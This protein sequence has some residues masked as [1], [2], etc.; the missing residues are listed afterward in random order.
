MPGSKPNAIVRCQA[1][2]S[3]NSASSLLRADP[4]L[5]ALY[6]ASVLSRVAFGPNAGRRL[7]RTGDQIDPDTIDALASPR[8]A[9]VSG[10]SLHANTAV[11]A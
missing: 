6:A 8:C 3:A 9:N 11:H 5:A 10:F 4:G 2:S 7:T 1:S